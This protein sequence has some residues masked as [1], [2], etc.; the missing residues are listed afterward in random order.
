[1]YNSIKKTLRTIFFIEL[2]IKKRFCYAFNELLKKTLRIFFFIELYIKNVITMLL[3]NYWKKH[4]IWWIIKLKTI[5]KKK[6]LSKISYMNLRK[7]QK[8]NFYLKYPI[9]TQ[10]KN[11]S[12]KGIRTLRKSQKK[13]KF[14]L[15]ISHTNPTKRKSLLKSPIRT[16]PI[17]T[18]KISKKNI[19]Y[20][21]Y[22]IRTLPIRKILQ[23]IFMYMY[24]FYW[25]I[26]L[27]FIYC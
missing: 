5:S 16:L 17:R 2:Y 15:K 14:L 7:S 20:Q 13:K 27:L 6:S 24:C 12:I 11:S 26:F 18:Q 8:K 9:R 10:K 1:M 25:I 21:R 22:P 4:F 19:F 3:I 23:P